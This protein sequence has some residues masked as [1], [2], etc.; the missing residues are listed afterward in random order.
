MQ[1]IDRKT[2]PCQ[3]V[4]SLLDE[5]EVREFLEQLTTSWQLIDDKKLRQELEFA[6][7]MDTMLFINDLAAIAEDADHH[8]DV[9]FS[10][11]KV[12]VELWTHSSGGLT[13]NDFILASR[14]EDIL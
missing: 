11:T 1:L 6:S 5:A 12:V 10:G 8:P 14:L 13:E 7:F 2:K 9:F 4:K 3:G